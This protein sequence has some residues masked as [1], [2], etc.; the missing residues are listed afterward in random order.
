MLD[1]CM[2]FQLSASHTVQHAASNEGME[3]SLVCIRQVVHSS[4]RFLS[5]AYASSSNSSQTLEN[6]RVLSEG[7]K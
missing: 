2:G 1:P 6:L 7:L 3:I 5:Q 4:R